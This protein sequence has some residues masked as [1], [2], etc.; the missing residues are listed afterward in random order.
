MRIKKIKKVKCEF[1]YTYED[2]FPEYRRCPTGC[3]YHKLGN[4]WIEC[5]IVDEYEREYERFKQ[6]IERKKRNT[7]KE[8]W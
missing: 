5:G 6:A 3:W 8:K 1:V 2:Y 7:N 4:D